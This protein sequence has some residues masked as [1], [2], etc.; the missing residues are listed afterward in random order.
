MNPMMEE[1]PLMQELHDIEGVDP[2]SWWPLGIGWWI[3]IGLFFLL[4]IISIYIMYRRNVFNRSWKRDALMQLTVLK[5]GLTEKTAR[6]TAEILS[7]YLRRITIKRYSR[8]E[9]AGL[10]D[11]DWLC[12]LAEHDPNKFDWK[13]K[14]RVLIDVAYAPLDKFP[15][16]GEVKELIQAV[17]GWVR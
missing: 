4:C 10:V 5:N 12:W 13:R 7:E 16:A 14:G 11:D 17:K 1:Y 2:V 9:C 15:S 6:E 3:V 8:K